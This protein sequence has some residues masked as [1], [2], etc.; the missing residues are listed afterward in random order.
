[1]NRFPKKAKRPEIPVFLLSGNVI[2]IRLGEK[3]ND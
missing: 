3:G 1:M 2:S